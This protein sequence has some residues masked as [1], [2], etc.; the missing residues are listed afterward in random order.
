ME[1]VMANNAIHIFGVAEAITPDS[2]Q[3]N[4]ANKRDIL[5]AFL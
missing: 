1:K 2:I 4:T 5:I 3:Q